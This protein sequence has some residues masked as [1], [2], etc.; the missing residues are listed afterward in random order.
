MGFMHAKPGGLTDEEASLY[1]D[2]DNRVAVSMD[3]VKGRA[4]KMTVFDEDGKLSIRDQW[5]DHSDSALEELLK[6]VGVQQ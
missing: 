3:Y 5:F 6:S 1:I 2:T 4:C